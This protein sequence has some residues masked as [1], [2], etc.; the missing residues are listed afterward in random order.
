MKYR[1]VI[2]HRG[3]SVIQHG[4]FNNRIYIMKLAPADI[5]DIIRYADD[6][7]RKEGYTK[8]F[9]KVPESSVEVFASDGYVSEA[10]VPFFYRGDEPAVFMGKY[11]DPKRKDIPD[12]TVMASVLSDAFSH[13]GERT[14][15]TVPAGFSVMHAHAGDADDISALFRTVFT[16]YPFPIDD[17]DYVRKTMQGSIRYFVMKKSHLLAAVASCEIDAENL[18]AEVTD[19]ATGPLFRGRGF[20]SLLLQSMETELKKEGIRLA[21]TICRA[22]FGPINTVFAG[23]GYEFGGMLPNNTNICGTVESMN[24]RYKKL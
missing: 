24:V 11:L 23:A 2:L 16:T 10:T 3:D 4:H 9:I 20:A 21:C 18:N 1:D 14:P 17:P 12:A 22:G 6:L 5:H 19:F 15:Y 8:I 7:A 13:A